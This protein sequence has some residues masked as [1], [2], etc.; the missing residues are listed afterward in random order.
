M[1]GK[2]SLVKNPIIEGNLTVGNLTIIGNLNV[3]GCITYNANT[4]LGECI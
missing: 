2:V 1:H 3:T 4:T